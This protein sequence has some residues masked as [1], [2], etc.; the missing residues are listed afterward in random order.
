MYGGYKKQKKNAG[1]RKRKA[2]LDSLLEAN[3]KEN[4]PLSLEDIRDQTNTFMFAVSWI[5]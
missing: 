2:F 4:N 5:F 3:E 1:Q